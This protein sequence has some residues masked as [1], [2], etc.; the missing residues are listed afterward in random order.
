MGRAFRVATVVLIFLAPECDVVRPE[1][2]RPPPKSP[3]VARSAPYLCDL[4]PASTF[5]AI[6]G[7]TVPLESDQDG[8]YAGDR[9]ADIERCRGRPKE[10][11]TAPLIVNWS[12]LKGE[13]SLRIHQKKWAN[14]SHG[15]IPSG[16]GRGFAAYERS[17]RLDVLPNEVFALFRCG[18]KR[19][20]ISIEFLSVSREGDV[21][22]D[23]RQDMFD[24]MRIAQKR[25]GEIRECTPRP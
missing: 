19:P 1:E 11:D 3:P 20:W 17:D 10:G 5:R 7:V 13:K 2:K 23:R 14:K 8:L 12:Y 25:F 6:T 16:L 15:R 24:L 18:G 9:D 21:K 4:V 22:R